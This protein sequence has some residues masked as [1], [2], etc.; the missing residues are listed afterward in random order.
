MRLNQPNEG[1]PSPDQAMLTKALWI[2][3]RIREM[4]TAMKTYHGTNYDREIAPYL[5]LLSSASGIEGNHGNPLLACI[6][7]IDTRPEWA[8]TRMLLAALAELED[9]QTE[10]NNRRN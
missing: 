1:G 4:R 9:Q 6:G 7:L 2:A 8:D 5:K 10:L 3:R